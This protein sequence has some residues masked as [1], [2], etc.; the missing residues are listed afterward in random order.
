[1]VSHVCAYMTYMILY[2]VMSYI[3]YNHSIKFWH[4]LT[5]TYKVF[6]YLLSYS[7]TQT[8]TWR[9]YCQHCRIMLQ[10]NVVRNTAWTYRWLDSLCCKRVMYYLI[11]QVNRFAIC[12]VWNKDLLM[13]FSICQLVTSYSVKRQQCTKT[14]SLSLAPS[15]SLDISYYFTI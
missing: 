5:F 10:K 2:T 14:R 3:I 15:L 7:M 8:A 9:F 12:C 6:L 11:T 4:L 1:M 13:L